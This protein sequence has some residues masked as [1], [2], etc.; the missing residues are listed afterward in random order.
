MYLSTNLSFLVDVNISPFASLICL[1][2]FSSIFSFISVSLSRPATRCNLSIYHFISISIAVSTHCYCVAQFF[3]HAKVS[4]P[5]RCRST[6]LCYRGVDTCKSCLTNKIIFTISWQAVSRK[7]CYL[8]SMNNT[9]SSQHIT[10]IH[11]LTAS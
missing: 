4:L 3:S 6:V 5:N 2:N 7:R 9:I 1:C 11:V 10:L 8:N